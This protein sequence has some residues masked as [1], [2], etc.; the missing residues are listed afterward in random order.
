[1][2]LKITNKITSLQDL[3]DRAK[4]LQDEIEGKTM[5][6]ICSGTGCKAYKSEEVRQA[7][8][9]EISKKGMENPE[10]VKNLKIFKTGCHGYCERGPIIVVHPEG[11]C[12]LRVKAGD[13]PAIIDKTLNGEIV[14]ELLFRDENGNPIVKEAEI[15]FYKYQKRIILD[16]NS[17]ID[18]ENIDDYIRIGGYQAL[19]KA[20]IMMSPEEIIQ[21]VKKANL[22]G[23]GGGGFPA[24][25]KWEVTRNTPGE[26]KYVIV[27]ADEGD[28]G[29]YMDRSVLEGDPHS[30]L[31]GLIIAAY[32]IGAHEGFI[33]IRQEYPQAVANLRVA[34]KKAEEYRLLGDNILNSGFKFDV[35]V[36]LGAGA[37]VSGE[38]TALMTAIEGSV[39]EPRFKYFPP[40]VSGLW[41]KPTNINN[42]ETYANIPYIIKNGAEWFKS[43]GTGKNPGTKIFS[44]VGKVNNTGLVEVPMGISLRDI[45]YK[46]GGGIKDNKKF[47]AVQT[48]GPSGG[49]IPEKLLDL[50]IDFDELNKAG[51]MMGSGGMIVMDESDCMVN[52]AQYF[53]KFLADESCGKCVPC[54]E[55]LRQMI[56][57]YDRIINGKGNIEDLDMLQDLSLLLEGASLCALGT[58]AKNIVSTTI[59]YFRNEYEAHINDKICPAKVCRPLIY[60]KINKEKCSGCMACLEVCPVNAI[61]GEAKKNHS[62][63]QSLCIKC[64]SCMD[65]CPKRFDAIEKKTGI[66]VDKMV[67]N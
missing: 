19:A 35:H 23:R 6:S 50:T 37:F 13:A 21:E 42:V 34:I 45:I 30:V 66:P 1:M 54:R 8:I 3:K 2:N 25:I 58:T 53:I 16:K 4:M 61:S 28:P 18:P 62:I 12:Y 36:H 33:Y 44:L 39:G 24:G 22:R 57:I 26:P 40:A 60:Y 5:I 20:L 67:D 7:L 48:G 17:K 14:E 27:N 49:V 63:D 31:E 15:P 52:I 51:S 11:T 64:G 65:V 32:A 47:K 38:E 41:G 55:G 46:I 29:A 10:K 9:D 59:K 43:F 56:H